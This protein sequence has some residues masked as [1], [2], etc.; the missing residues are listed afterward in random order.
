MRNRQTKRPLTVTP[1]SIRAFTLLIPLVDTLA[2]SVPYDFGRSPPFPMSCGKSA[3]GPKKTRPPPH[4]ISLRFPL[5]PF[6]CPNPRGKMPHGPTED[7]DIP[8]DVPVIQ[9]VPTR[10]DL[11][12]PTLPKQHPQAMCRKEELFSSHLIR[13]SYICA[14]FPA[15]YRLF[16][17][18]LKDSVTAQLAP[19]N[20]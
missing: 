11:H 3:H 13:S 9:Y 17:A 15:V 19:E 6:H 10:C 18:S 7:T 4:S 1:V 12:N 16:V 14:L 5:G 8:H 20:V 2:F